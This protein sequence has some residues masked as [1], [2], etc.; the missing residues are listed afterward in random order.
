MSLPERKAEIFSLVLETANFPLSPL[1]LP[2]SVFT[3]AI[4][5]R[6]VYVIRWR[7]HS[8][9]GAW[10]LSSLLTDLTREIRL[11]RRLGH[12]LRSWHNY[13]AIWAREPRINPFRRGP[14]TGRLFPGNYGEIKEPRG[15]DARTPPTVIRGGSRPATHRSLASGVNLPA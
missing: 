14:V 9:P 13:D 8:W 7:P 4:Y 11:S 3:A 12:G 10:K 2:P 5:P 15:E 6:S 1:L